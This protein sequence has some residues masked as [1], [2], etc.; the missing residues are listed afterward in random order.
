MSGYFKDKTINRDKKKLNTILI[1]IDTII[2]IA[3]KSSS[4]TITLIGFGL[5][6]IPITNSIAC[7]LLNGN[8]VKYETVI[9]KYNKHKNQYQKD[10]Q[11]IDSFD[12]L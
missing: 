12:K 9:Q 11:T 10:Q 7:G 8:K 3:A 6:V 2:I 1:S 5:K 4:I